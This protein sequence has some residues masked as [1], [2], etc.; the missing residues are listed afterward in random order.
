MSDPGAATLSLPPSFTLPRCG[1]SL[2]SELGYDSATPSVRAKR[3]SKKRADRAPPRT[4]RTSW[5]PEPP[6]ATHEV[7]S[8]R[9][10]AASGGAGLVGP[11]FSPWHSCATVKF[12]GLILGGA[13]HP[14]ALLLQNRSYTLDEM[15][16]VLSS[17][18]FSERLEPMAGLVLVLE[19]NEDDAQR[20]KRHDACQISWTGR[21]PAVARR[22]TTA[23][24]A[25]V[26]ITP[27]K[28]SEAV[29]TVSKN[30][31][32]VLRSSSYS[33][34]VG[35]YHANSAF[36][37]IELVTAI[38][39]YEAR[40][41]SAMVRPRGAAVLDF[42]VLEDGRAEASARPTPPFSN[43]PAPPFLSPFSRH[44]HRPVVAQIYWRAGIASSPPSLESLL[45]LP[46]A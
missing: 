42:V 20:R 32:L 14:P 34:V 21:W 26:V 25:Q 11:A 18:I 9:E 44:T 30:R 19:A 35:V 1:S 7:H 27:L 23:G 36:T 8:L 6:P 3:S 43:H 45:A 2:Q 4:H 31:L 29:A 10:L 39:D 28:L 16:C 40:I 15:D 22:R 38:Y 12:G 46:S 33:E 37:L 5:R 41:R 17:E 24:G 13:R